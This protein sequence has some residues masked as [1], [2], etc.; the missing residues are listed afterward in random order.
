MVPLKVVNARSSGRKNSYLRGREGR[1][2][3]RH[4]TKIGN[5]TLAKQTPKGAFSGVRGEWTKNSI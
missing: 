4:R 1:V 5:F 2:L 3:N